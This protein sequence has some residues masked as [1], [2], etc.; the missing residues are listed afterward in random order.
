MIE[1]S[2]VEYM[3]PQGMP[4]GIVARSGMQDEVSTIVLCHLKV[5]EI[6]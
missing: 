2:H 5:T 1:G 3:Y 4:P 6:P